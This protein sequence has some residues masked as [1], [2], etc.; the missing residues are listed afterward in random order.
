MS[1]RLVHDTAP[2]AVAAATNA[3]RGS[4]HCNLV[5]PALSFAPM[6]GC[7]CVARHEHDKA[8]IGSRRLTKTKRFASDM[9][10][11]CATQG[12]TDAAGP[13]SRVRGR[14]PSGPLVSARSHGIT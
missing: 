6:G 8:C 14:E 9:P 2:A 7:S 1:V 13:A 3:R 5:R 4:F 10:Y 11:V 12:C